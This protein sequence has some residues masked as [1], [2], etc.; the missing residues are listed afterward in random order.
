MPSLQ[1]LVLR[2]VRILKYFFSVI[3][4]CLFPRNESTARLFRLV[5]INQS[6]NDS[7]NTYYY[8]LESKATQSIYLLFSKLI[9]KR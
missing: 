2:M 6:N 3:R 4:G 1:F 5:I 9:C 8:N 7:G